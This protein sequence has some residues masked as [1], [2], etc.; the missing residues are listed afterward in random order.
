MRKF[1][2]P[3]DWTIPL[4]PCKIIK[5]LENDFENYI[6]DVKN[7]VFVNKYDFVLTHFNEDINTVIEEY[8]RRI[9]IF[10]NIIQHP[11]K[12]YF[13][14]INEDYLYNEKYR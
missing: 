10:R 12:K 2:L 6:P 14:Y 4:Y 9:E 3:F 1:S 13:I 5:V 7:C 8:T 11:K